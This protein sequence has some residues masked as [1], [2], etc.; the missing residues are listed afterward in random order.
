ML[1][2]GLKAY[3]STEPPSISYH[4]FKNYAS[5]PI[6]EIVKVDSKGRKDRDETEEKKGTN[7]G[8]AW[9]GPLRSSHPYFRCFP[10]PKAFLG[11]GQHSPWSYQEPKGVT[12]PRP[13]IPVPLAVCRLDT[14]TRTVL[15]HH[16]I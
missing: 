5:V 14:A 15:Q 8:V 3:G 9:S 1:R 16:M 6:I 4:Q 2:L 13:A 11:K 7:H 12:K 10:L